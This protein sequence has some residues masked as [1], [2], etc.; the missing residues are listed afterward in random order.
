MKKFK[1]TVDRVYVKEVYVYADDKDH[2]LE[3]ASEVSDGMEHDWKT[4]HESNWYANEVTDFDEED[5]D[6]YKPIQDYLK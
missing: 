6:V 2:A 3:I 4:F 1:L 5:L